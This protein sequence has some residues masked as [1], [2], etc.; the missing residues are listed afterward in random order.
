MDFVL[1]SGFN[2]KKI[3]FTFGS[4]LSMETSITSFFKITEKKKS[5][6]NIAKELR[7]L[8]RTELKKVSTIKDYFTDNCEYFFENGLRKVHP[9]YYTFQT[10]VKERWIAR[11]ISSVFMEEF[12]CGRADY[13]QNRIDKGFLLINQEKVS[14]DYC[15]HPS[16]VITHR[17]HR[18]E[19]PVLDQPLKIIHEDSNNLVICKP[20][21]IP[22]HSVNKYH[23]NTVLGIMSKQYGIDQ[24]RVVHRI[25]R[26][27]SGILIIAKNYE[28]SLKISTEILKRQVSKFFLAVVNGDFSSMGNEPVKCD[29]PL[30]PLSEKLG[31]FHA[32]SVNDGGKESSTKFL[33]LKYNP[34]L[35]LSLILCKPFT[36]RTHQIRVHLQY[37]G[38]PISNDPLYNSV[39]WG[40]NLGKGGIYHKSKEQ[41]IEDL[42]ANH[43]ILLHQAL[44]TGD[45]ESVDKSQNNSVSSKYFDEN[46]DECSSGMTYN[47]DHESLILYLHAYRYRSTEKDWDYHTDL[48]EWTQFFYKNDENE[49][50]SAEIQ[51]L[52]LE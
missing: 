42:H 5:N 23:F 31:L 10:F 4:E 14:P 17:I 35:N 11:S 50:A 41:L 2:A 15:L 49:K 9:Y 33:F 8:K 27:T 12:Y 38:F 18:H 3:Q 16:D 28:S 30:G 7:K 43:N 46:C 34:E 1:L 40:P 44:E 37:L 39:A 36:G 21:S 29:I 26:M 6:E 19:F 20:S 47:I 13:V 52:P 22:I 32:L 25:D 51:Q 48:P 45:L 24:L